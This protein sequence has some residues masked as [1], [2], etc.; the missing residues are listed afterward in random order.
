MTII[1]A[2]LTIIGYSMNDTVV[3]FDRLR[4]N[5]KKYKKMSLADVIDLSTNETLSRTMITSLDGAVV[6]HRALD[7]GRRNAAWFRHRDD[8]RDC[9]RHLFVD[10]CGRARHSLVAQPPR[11]WS[12]PGKRAD[13]AGR[14]LER[15]R[16]QTAREETMAWFLSNLRYVAWTALAVGVLFFIWYTLGVR[17][18]TF[19][20]GVFWEAGLRWL[21]VLSGIMWIGLLYYFNFVQTPNMAKIPDEQKPAISKVIAPAALFWFRWSAMST[22]DL[23]AA[24]GVEREAISSQALSFGLVGEPL[25]RPS[26]SS[27]ASACGWPSSCGSTFGS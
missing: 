26:R 15:E 6:G 22:L 11:T 9:D 18:I 17:G 16:S 10:L 19:G 8:F 1:A 7:G 21:H 25:G 3:V 12:K 4:E 23:R 13:R 20:E 24:A 27:S 14:E 2:L 5:L